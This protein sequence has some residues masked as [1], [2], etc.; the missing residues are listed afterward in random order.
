MAASSIDTA[1]QRSLTGKAGRVLTELG[2]AGS[3]TTA[4][5][6]T[7]VD[8]P[9][10]SMYRL[11]AAMLDLR[12][13]ERSSESGGFRVGPAFIRLAD[14]CERQVDLRRAARPTL[15]ELHRETGLPVQL[16]VPRSGRAVCIDTVEG[17]NVQVVALQL[18][19]SL[20]M[21]TGATSLAM[22]AFDPNQKAA[23]ELAPTL[24]RIRRTGVCSSTGNPAEGVVTIASPVL[25][26]RG[27]VV[28]AVSIGGLRTVLL[29]RQLEF[30]AAV[31]RAA[32]TVSR[33]LGYNLLHQESA[34]ASS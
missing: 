18:G 12:W 27:E 30:E 20:P 15:V 32:R 10:S 4:E 5:L 24:A 31:L 11:L 3:L 9:T 16:S 19:E 21:G 22:L 23:E 28:A 7:R 29:N 26:H 34:D 14:A 25:D 17:S 13:V 2:L 8:E 1:G 33:Q 6:A